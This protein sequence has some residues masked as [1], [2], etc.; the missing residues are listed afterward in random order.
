MKKYKIDYG[1]SSSGRRAW[2]WGSQGFIPLHY[3]DP[4]DYVDPWEKVSLC[5]VDMAATAPW[6]PQYRTVLCGN[7]KHTLP[8]WKMQMDE[9]GW[10]DRP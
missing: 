7:C 8:G 9:K 4:W 5:G 1:L 6:P 2:V 3:V 10:Y